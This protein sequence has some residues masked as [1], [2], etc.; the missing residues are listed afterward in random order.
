MIFLLTR[1]EGRDRSLHFLTECHFISLISG[2]SG[3][4][5][6]QL[7]LSRHNPAVA[8]FPHSVEQIH[9]S[10]NQLSTIGTPLAYPGTG[11]L[12]CG[13]SFCFSPCFWLLYSFSWWQLWPSHLTGAIAMSS[14]TTC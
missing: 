13:T 5:V 7:R 1:S 4:M 3:P 11:E 8:T 9:P 6:L 10:S 14:V 12:V 2:K